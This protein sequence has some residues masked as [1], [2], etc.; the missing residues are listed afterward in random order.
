MA[1]EKA[2]TK[3]TGKAG[4]KSSRWAGRQPVK[5]ASKK[6]RRREDKIETKGR[7]S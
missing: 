2:R 4:S 7:K 1:L 5:E 6:H 3:G